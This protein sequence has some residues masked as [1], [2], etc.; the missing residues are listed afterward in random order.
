MRKPLFTW[1]GLQRSV[2]PDFGLLAARWMA[3]MGPMVA[4]RIHTHRLSSALTAQTMHA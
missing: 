4:A 2:Q 1:P 3:A